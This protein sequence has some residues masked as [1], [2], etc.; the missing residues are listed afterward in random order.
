MI[1]LFGTIQPIIPFIDYLL[2]Y[3]YIVENICEQ[4]EELENLC[5]GNCYLSDQL[6][7][8][9]IESQENQQE[10][11]TENYINYF[12]Y[13]FLKQFVF[14]VQ[15]KFDNKYINANSVIVVLHES[16]PISPPP[17]MFV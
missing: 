7:Q 10:R 16:E 6:L 8:K 3:E 15:N 2:N 5:M 9:I 13:H 12:S 14:P 11:K 17:R 4:R 1:Y